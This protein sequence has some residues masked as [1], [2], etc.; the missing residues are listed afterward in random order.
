MDRVS[1]SSNNIRAV[2]Y[3]PSTS[4]LEVEFTTGSIYQY[5]CVPQEEFDAMINAASK[6][7]YFGANIR[8]KS[9]FVK[10]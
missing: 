5:H 1:V 2:G 9:T 10:L 7:K 8:N 6:G 4:T 3:D